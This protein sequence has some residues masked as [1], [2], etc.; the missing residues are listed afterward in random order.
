MVYMNRMLTPAQYESRK[1]STHLPHKTLICDPALSVGQCLQHIFGEDR[2]YG[3]LVGMQ[4][5]EVQLWAVHIEGVV[6]LVSLLVGKALPSL[7]HLD[8]F[9]QLGAFIE[10]KDSVGVVPGVEIQLAR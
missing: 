6:K 9:K 10:L 2:L 3:A 8:Q 5:G 4:L 1:A 7:E